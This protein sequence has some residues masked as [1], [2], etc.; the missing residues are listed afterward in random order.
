MARLLG[1][2]ALDNRL[3][4]NMAELNKGMAMLF[5]LEKSVLS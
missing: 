4:I 5:K 2:A 1:E 3:Q